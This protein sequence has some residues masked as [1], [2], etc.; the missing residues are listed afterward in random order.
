MV[1]TVETIMA[2]KFQIILYAPRTVMQH[3]RLND[4]RRCGGELVIGA[5][6]PQSCLRNVCTNEVPLT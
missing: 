4:L 3:M 5:R 2:M 6:N 1:K